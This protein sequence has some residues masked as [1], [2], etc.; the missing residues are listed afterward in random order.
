MR[1]DQHPLIDE[2]PI[3]AAVGASERRHGGAGGAV[4]HDSGAKRQVA[5]DV[6]GQDRHTL[7]ARSRPRRATT[8]R[9]LAALDDAQRL[10]HAGDGATR[11]GVGRRL[12]PCTAGRVR[13]LRTGAQRPHRSG[14]SQCGRGESRVIGLLIGVGIWSRFQGRRD[15]F[16]LAECRGEV[17]D[18]FAGDD[19]WCGQVVEVL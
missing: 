4:P 18:N 7:R 13:R 17:L 16:E 19:L 8:R 15:G 11:S 9:P 3:A 14:S 2:Q 12:R 6:D 1:R 5:D 10:L